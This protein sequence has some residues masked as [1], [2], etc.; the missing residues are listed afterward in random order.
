MPSRQDAHRFAGRCG[1][2]SRDSA[3][4]QR[5]GR[6]AARSAARATQHAGIPG[7]PPRSTPV[8]CCSADAARLSSRPFS[9]YIA[10]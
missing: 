7:W 2:R 10:A 5:E 9:A 6:G 1:A 3:K 4:G 8:I